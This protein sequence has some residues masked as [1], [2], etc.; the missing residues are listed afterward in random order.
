VFSTV[1][2][3]LAKT[4]VDQLPS[5]LNKSEFFEKTCKEH[6]LI[7][8][9]DCKNDLF[10]FEGQ[11]N[12]FLCIEAFLQKCLIDWYS[13]S[14]YELDENVSHAECQQIEERTVQN[15]L[16]VSEDSVNNNVQSH[17]EQ[18]T[19]I[20][21][22]ISVSNEHQIVK[23]TRECKDQVNSNDASNDKG[24]SYH[25]NEIYLDIQLTSRPSNGLFEDSGNTPVTVV[26]GTEE[27]L[28]EAICLG[29]TNT[30]QM[31][32]ENCA[33]SESLKKDHNTAEDQ[34][35]NKSR[36]YE[37]KAQFKYFCTLCSF[38]S[39][40]QSH[41][42]KHALLHERVCK[43]YSCEYCDFSTIRLGHLQRHVMQHSESQLTCPDCNYRTHS[44]SLLQKHTNH[45]HK[46]VL[47]EEAKPVLQCSKC[48]YSTTKEKF[49]QRHQSVHTD[50]KHPKRGSENYFECSKCSFKTTLKS[51]LARHSKNVHMTD[52]PFLCTV[53][54]QGFKRS[55][56]LSQHLVVHAGSNSSKKELQC[57]QCGKFYRSKKL[58]R[59]HSLVHSD[60][61]S[62]LCEI[63][64]AAFKTR[65]VQQKHVRTVHSDSRTFDCN[66]CSKKFNSN[67]KLKRHIKLHELKTAPCSSSQG[68]LQAAESAPADSKQVPA[69]SDQSQSSVMTL[70]IPEDVQVLVVQRDDIQE[71]VILNE[72]AIGS[73]PA[74]SNQVLV[75]AVS[76]QSESSVMT[77]PIPEDVQMLVVQQDDIQEGAIFNEGAIESAPADSNQILVPAV[78]DQS[79]SSA[80][81]LPIP[82]DFQVLVVQQDDIQ[83]GVI[84]NDGA[85]FVQDSAEVLVTN[86]SNP[87]ESANV[88]VLPVEY[89][90]SEELVSQVCAATGLGD[91]FS[92]QDGEVITLQFV[93]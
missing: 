74:D 79:E 34:K 69:A 15:P 46:K 5:H 20:T 78:S 57:Q 90:F 28:L 48:T 36:K 8:E 65:A 80:M 77:L 56:T 22:D 75:P 61:R 91:Q 55:D 30:E 12:D 53:C 39:K 59:E 54:G 21:E 58:L 38:K 29:P 17:L 27:S 2:G 7:F 63:C 51:N 83:E 50:N 42:K 76:D 33:Q 14:N 37:E 4:F 62:Y 93:Q 18:E 81:T 87:S 64:G 6:N 43:L 25:E 47:S 66:L 71:G 3:L 35:K 68:T 31:Q 41:L 86:S 13:S 92:I 82:E 23:S 24:A 9:K 60:A 49:F 40:R 67:Y 89:V 45:K 88:P 16:T 32:I 70:P 11:W 19:Q 10:S 73:A 1:R 26:M 85:I 72:G 84:F 44:I 52:R